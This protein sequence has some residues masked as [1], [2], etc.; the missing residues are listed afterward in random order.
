MA[1]WS[2]FAAMGTM[3]H[4][5]V[6][7]LPE[8]AAAEAASAAQTVVCEV[9]AALSRFRADSDVGRL[10]AFPGEWLPVGRHLVAVAQAAA[11][12]RTLTRGAF[13]AITGGVPPDVGEESE[14][15]GSG[16]GCDERLA[17]RRV[18]EAWEA[19]LA[20]GCAVDYGAIAKGYA[21]DLARDA[22]RAPGVL[23]SLGT[24]SIAMAG[25]PP[26]RDVWRVAIGSPWAEVADSLGYL[27]ATQGSFSLSGVRGHRLGQP[28]RPGHV[29]D[30]RTGD[31]AR[32]D[33]CAV[34]VLSDRAS[35][36]DGAPVDGPGGAG[37]RSE[38]LS[39]ACLVLG[40]DAGLDLCHTLRAS[41]IL[42]T[43]SGEIRA[44]PGLAPRVSLRAGI[45]A[46]LRRPKGLGNH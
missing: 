7:G 19:R 3:A 39:T 33:A 38:A 26:E 30:P 46:H 35:R 34:G 6:V 13:D 2:Q 40:V 45:Q 15:G 29:R 31:P 17:L 44:T 10:N 14:Q 16:A 22:V 27:E 25:T 21:A 42:L 5:C 1:R 43:A 36:D 24:S 32:T 41:A 4:V 18:G 12:Y 9:E 20:P 11:R 37:M 23:V 28:V 8:G